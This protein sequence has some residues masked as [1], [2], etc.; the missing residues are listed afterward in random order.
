M[1]NQWSHYVTCIGN[2]EELHEIIRRRRREKAEAD[3]ARREE[4]GDAPLPL[5]GQGMLGSAF[6]VSEEVKALNQWIELI[7]MKGMPISDVECPIMREH[8]KYT[9]VK[10][11]KTVMDTAHYLVSRVEKKIANLAKDSP[12]GQL[13]FDGY[14]VGGVHYVALFASFM[15]PVKRK[16]DG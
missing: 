9:N 2:T 12:K 1:G 6:V 8:V 10:S 5:R 7:V 4:D 13:I 16:V 15:E 3:A 14:T 11:S